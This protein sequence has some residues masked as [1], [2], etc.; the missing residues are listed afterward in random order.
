M[1]VTPKFRKFGKYELG[2]Q[3]ELPDRAAKVLILV[4]KVTA[5]EPGPQGYRTR[6]MRADAVPVVAVELDSE[7]IEW[8]AEI[9]AASKFKKA[10]GT[11]RKRAGRV[12][13]SEE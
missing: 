7:G 5:V 10:D 9:H 4:G 6:D 1:K 11:W 12:A 8:N 3:F 2:Q 13:A